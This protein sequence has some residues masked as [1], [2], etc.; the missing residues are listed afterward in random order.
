MS[1]SDE[2][3]RTIEAVHAAG[4]D[5]ERWPQALAAAANLIGGVAGVFEVLDKRTRTPREWHGWAVPKASEIQYLAEF[6]ALSPRASLGFR[7]GAGA[8]A[9][10]QLVIDERAMKRDPFYA[11]FLAR[12]GFRY[13]ISANLLQNL[14]EAVVFSIQ[15]SPTQ[16]HVGEREVAL[17]R[18]L[19]PHL[20]QADDVARRLKGAQG[21]GRSF[22]RAFD[23]LSD[24]VVL[25]NRDGAI[26][27][28][29]MAMQDIARRGDGIRIVKA[30]LT[31]ADDRAVTRYAAA[32]GQIARLRGGAPG[33]STNDFAARRAGGTPPYLV[34]VRPLARHDGGSDA[35]AIVF[36]HDPLKPK[37]GSRDLLRDTFGLTEAEAALAEALQGGMEV[38]DYASSRRLTLNTVYTHLRRVKEKTGSVRLPDL[39]HKLNDLQI[40][41][42]RV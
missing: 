26:V 9:Y 15:R 7:L 2:L 39:I 28:T 30:R 34:S 21:T 5:A 17:M 22:E 38:S 35:V 32:L 12:F 36:V 24:G 40:R 41:V 1:E 42:R 14:D 8:I 6:A 31:P 25:V 27:Y 18:Q 19:A 33:A 37:S 3:I 16:G 20:Q 13:F 10:D 4:L 29:N 23:W 11:D